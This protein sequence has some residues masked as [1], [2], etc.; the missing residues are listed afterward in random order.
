MEQETIEVNEDST[1][2]FVQPLQQDNY[3]RKTPSAFVGTVVEKQP[4]V[5]AII[6]S[7]IPKTSRGNEALCKLVNKYPGVFS[8]EQDPLTVTPN[9]IHT[10]QQTTNE[11]YRKRYPIPVIYHEQVEKQLIALQEQGIILPSHSAYNVPLIPVPKKNGGL[12]LCLDFR[13]LNTTLRD[14]RYP[15]P[16]IQQMLYQLGK[17]MIF[18]CLDLKQSYH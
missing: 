11:V 4:G 14:D 17:S 5:Q 10:I 12:R 8:T 3:Q 16:N 9:F 13:A 7:K 18:T 1:L 15:L 2:S 6:D